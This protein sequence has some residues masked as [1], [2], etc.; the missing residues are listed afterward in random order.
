[1]FAT[2]APK[3]SLSASTGPFVVVSLISTVLCT[4]PFAFINMMCMAPRLVPPASSKFAPTA[5]SFMPSLFRSPMFA[6]DA[7]KKS[8]SA[9]TG[10]FVVV[11]LI[12]T[13]ELGYALLFVYATSEPNSNCIL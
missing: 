4:V 8:P 7:P 10:P 1:M 5:M 3:K 13:T 12:S 2:D 11:S 9:S 6:T